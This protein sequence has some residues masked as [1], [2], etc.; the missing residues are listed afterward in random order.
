MRS[1]SLKV[2]WLPLPIAQP[3]NFAEFREKSQEWI[4]SARDAATDIF[5]TAT[6][7]IKAVSERVQSVN[8]PTLEVPQF[9]KDLLSSGEDTHGERDHSHKGPGASGKGRPGGEDAAI[10]A[11]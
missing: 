2:S 11:L 7:G 10:A 8:L 6:G 3:K 4:T 5:D 1:T 9:F